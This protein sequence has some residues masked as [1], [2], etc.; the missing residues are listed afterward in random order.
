MDIYELERIHSEVAAASTLDIAL[1]ETSKEN[2]RTRILGS[3]DPRL[4]TFDCV[5]M[6]TPDFTLA[7]NSGNPLLINNLLR[8]VQ[9]TCYIF[10]SLNLHLV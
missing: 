3:G 9:H 8:W 6:K 1:E 4:I 10:V 5:T 7:W 2:K